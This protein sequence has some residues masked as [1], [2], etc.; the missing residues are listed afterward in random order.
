MSGSRWT[1]R[2]V[3]A[4]SV[5]VFAAAGLVAAGPSVAAPAAGGQDGGLASI[6]DPVTGQE[7]VAGA[8]VQ[9]DPITAGV[10]RNLAGLYCRSGTIAY[11]IYFRIPYY[12][13]LRWNFQFSWCWQNKSQAFA[14]A[15]RPVVVQASSGERRVHKNAAIVIEGDWRKT[16]GRVP[17]TVVN[18]RYDG[19]RFRYCPV[20][21]L[22]C[23][24]QFA[25]MIDVYLLAGGGLTN[26]SVL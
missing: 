13:L 1:V 25:P 11:L 15:D 5:L 12:E 3:A 4:L 19:M 17:S 10:T 6:I 18:V 2:L 16:V 23:F 14:A 21:P 22:G 9:T 26:S 20:S 7:I 8:E 24:G